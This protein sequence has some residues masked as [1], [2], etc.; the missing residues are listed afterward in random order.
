MKKVLLLALVFVLSASLLLGCGSLTG[1]QTVTCNEL[2]LTIPGSFEDWSSDSVEE[3]IAFNYAGRKIG[4]CGI[5]EDKAYLQ[6]F[7]PDIDTQSYAELF[8]ETNALISQVGTV[9]G[10]VT[11]EYTVSGDPSATYL[12]GVF[13]SQENFWVIQAYCEADDFAD[14]KADMWSYIRTVTVS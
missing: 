6:E 8:V 12:C 2:Q 3:G 9:D 10:I 1:E 7:L 11:F 14:C 13:E 5:F 4:I